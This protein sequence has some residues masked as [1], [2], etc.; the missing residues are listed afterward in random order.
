MKQ[1]FRMGVVLLLASPAF[2]YGQECDMQIRDGYA[3]QDLARILRCFDQRLKKLEEGGAAASGRV[4][5][6]PS[7]KNAAVFE[8]GDFTVAARATS[9][10]KTDRGANVALAIQNR[11]AEQILLGVRQGVDVVVIGE[12]TG[13][14]RIVSYGAI[15]GIATVGL[16]SPAGYFTQVPIKSTLNFTIKL[17]DV[18]NMGSNLSLSLPLYQ[19]KDG[20]AQQV[21]VP[22]SFVMAGR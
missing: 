21:T 10:S 2:V 15:V 19:F 5:S 9:G 8:A 17:S 3:A 4:T 14:S 1:G 16:H 12:R 11:A 13:E 6:E 18:S 7:T 22:L 20:K